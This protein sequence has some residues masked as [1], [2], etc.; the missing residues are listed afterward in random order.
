VLSPSTAHYDRH[1]KLQ[2]YQQVPSL[3]AVVLFA[4]DE[5]RVDLWLR[6]SAGWEH[7]RY[8]AGDSVPLAAIGCTL[9]VDTVYAAARDA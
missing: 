4:H 8:G 2:H 6:G 9:A 1:E 3:E 5:S 7:Q